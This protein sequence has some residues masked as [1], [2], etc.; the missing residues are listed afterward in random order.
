MKFKIILPVIVLL[1]SVT[2]TQSGYMNSIFDSSISFF[3]NVRRA[4][5]RFIIQ[6]AGNVSYSQYTL[7]KSDISEDNQED[8]NLQL[9]GDGTEYIRVKK[10]KTFDGGLTY[11]IFT[12]FVRAV[13]EL[14][15]VLLNFNL[16]VF[17]LTRFNPLIYRL[18]LRK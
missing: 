14:N 16:S 11:H 3:E 13:G 10:N 8:K 15:L 5:K 1:L 6:D 7:I 12:D 4:Y 18:Y 9:M 17:I 2:M